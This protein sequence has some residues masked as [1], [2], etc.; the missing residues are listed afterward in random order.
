MS[1]QIACSPDGVSATID[2]L[3]A[4][5]E[6]RGIGVFARVDH[7][8]GAR[9][10]GLELAEEEVLV[11]GDPRAGTLLMQADPR[12]GYELPLRILAW[13]DAGQTKVAF[14]PPAELADGYELT[15]Q[16]V[17]LARM[18]TL[19]RELVRDAAAG[20]SPAA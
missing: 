8:G 4:A 13:D 16:A 11:F 2:R 12:V 19:L 18:D 5:L 3:V 15:A 1:L 7:G 10:A 9:A 14:R 6:S 20:P 17:V